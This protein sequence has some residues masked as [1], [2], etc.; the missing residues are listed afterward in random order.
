MKDILI[1]KNSPFYSEFFRS[2][3]QLRSEEMIYSCHSLLYGYLDRLWF[4]RFIHKEAIQSALYEVF[5]KRKIIH[6]KF[7]QITGDTN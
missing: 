4:F 3:G 6:L 2:D 1:K 5:L 7:I